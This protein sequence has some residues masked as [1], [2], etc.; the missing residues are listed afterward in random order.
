MVRCTLGYELSTIG[1]PHTDIY[2]QPVSRARLPAV[3]FHLHGRKFKPAESVKA[4]ASSPIRDHPL[5]LRTEV[6]RR[7]TGEHHDHV[8]VGF[9]VA[10]GDLDVHSRSCEGR[11]TPVNVI[12]AV[13]LMR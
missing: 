10:A 8:G 2:S 11:E 9:G 6:C 1:R 7:R 3:D 4:P 5:E 13:P 12:E